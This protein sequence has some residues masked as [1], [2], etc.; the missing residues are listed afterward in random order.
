MRTIAI[1]L[2]IAG[3][4]GGSASA[5]ASTAGTKGAGTGVPLVV[6]KRLGGN[7]PPTV[8]AEVRLSGVPMRQ[9]SVALGAQRLAAVMP[10]VSVVN[11]SGVPLA[12]AKRL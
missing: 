4:A 3:L 8:A 9:A 6:A 7:T 10:V 11:V 5:S 1:L 2:A 12:R